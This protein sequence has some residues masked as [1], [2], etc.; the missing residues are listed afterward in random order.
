MPSYGRAYLIEKEK[1]LL[2]SLSGIEEIKVAQKL[3]EMGLH[4][5][6]YSVIL[7]SMQFDLKDILDWWTL[8]I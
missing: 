1:S 6:E 7:N 2:N 4:D 3:K 5:F 8:W